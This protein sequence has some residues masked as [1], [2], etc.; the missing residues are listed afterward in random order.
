MKKGVKIL[1]VLLISFLLMG[2]E[3]KEVVKKCTLSVNNTDNG[4]SLKSTYE[5]H[6]KNNVVN[7]VKTKEV[8]T[9]EKD[10]ILSYFEKTLNNTYKKA[11]DTY[12]GYTYNVKNDNNKVTSDVKIDYNKMNLKKYVSDNSVMKSYVNSNNKLTLK[13]AIKIYENLGATCKD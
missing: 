5:I 12:G 6:A 3:E 8:V 4:Y 10:S 7:S 1:S 2:C 11:N 9:S 13:G